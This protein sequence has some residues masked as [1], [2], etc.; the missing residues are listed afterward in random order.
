M[1]NGTF[2]FFGCPVICYFE[3]SFIKD[4]IVLQSFKNRINITVN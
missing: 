3:G 4:S 2:F 1:H